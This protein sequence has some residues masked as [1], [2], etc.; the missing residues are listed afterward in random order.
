V[1]ILAP[2]LYSLIHHPPHHG[3]EFDMHVIMART[4]VP[5]LLILALGALSFAGEP[6]RPPA[7]SAPSIAGTYRLV[8]RQFP[9]GTMLKPP[10]VMGLW[11][12]TKTHRHLN[13][14]RK[15]TTGTFASFSIVSTYTLT[16]TAYTETL[17]FSLRTDQPG[18]KD[19]VY[20]LSGQTQSA[21]VTADGGRLQF[22]LP[23]EPRALVFEGNKITATAA[24]NANVDTW[25]KVE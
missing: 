14:I 4:A 9:D 7:S 22:T 2:V 13:T 5:M 24:N 6:S 25:E 18:G 10:E 20:D 12:Y 21:P 15:D 23:F 11:T 17:L 8:S 19:P 1:P 3:K 16:A